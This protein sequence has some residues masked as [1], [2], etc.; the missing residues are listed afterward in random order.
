[1]H[2]ELKSESSTNS[3]GEKE[4]EEVESEHEGDSV[5]VGAPRDTVATGTVEGSGT[6]SS[7]LEGR[8]RAADEDAAQAKEVKRARVEHRLEGLQVSPPPVVNEERREDK[9]GARARR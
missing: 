9:M 6:S 4:S 2:K 5:F 1:M 7:A 8:K 3:D